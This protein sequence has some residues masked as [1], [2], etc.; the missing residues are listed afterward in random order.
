M[1][2]R[3][4]EEKRRFQLFCFT[5]V[6][7]IECRWCKIVV[8]CET[9]RLDEI[10][11]CLWMDN[12]DTNGIALI[13]QTIFIDQMWF[14]STISNRTNKKERWKNHLVASNTNIMTTAFKLRWILC[15]FR[16]FPPYF[17]H[18]FCIIH[19]DRLHGSK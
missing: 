19:N 18:G 11:N 10:V 9:L 4:L 6:V 1:I 14:K 16:C 8:A 17:Y 15:I 3:F 2:V 12:R 7:N 13:F 5:R